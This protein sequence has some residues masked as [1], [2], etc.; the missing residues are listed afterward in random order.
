VI[1]FR[2]VKTL[3][4]SFRDGESNSVMIDEQSASPYKP[5]ANEPKSRR[6]RFFVP[7]GEA[8]I[9]VGIGGLLFAVA[10]ISLLVTRKMSP[11]KSELPIY[12]KWLESDLVSLAIAAPLLAPIFAFLIAYT[13]RRIMPERLL[14]FVPWWSKDLRTILASQKR[15]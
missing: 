15:S 8:I 6:P 5:P 4:S 14:K 13:I 2:I 9:F 1:C 7:L 10:T 12:L 11:N 3:E